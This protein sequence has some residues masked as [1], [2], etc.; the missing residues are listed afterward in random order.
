M[1]IQKKEM[2]IN[3]L[4]ATKYEDISDDDDETNREQENVAKRD[5]KVYKCLYCAQLHRGLANVKNHIRKDHAGSNPR[6]QNPNLIR[7]PPAISTPLI[8]PGFHPRLPHSDH[9]VLRPSTI[10]TRNTIP[11]PQFNQFLNRIPNASSDVI[12][13]PR[14]RPRGSTKKTIGNSSALPPGRPREMNPS[15]N[16]N[17]LSAR[18][19]PG[20]NIH[21]RFPN[22]NVIRSLHSATSAPHFNS[23][24]FNQLLNNRMSNPLV[25]GPPNIPDL[26]PF[27]DL[28]PSLDLGPPHTCHICKTFFVN[29]EQYRSHL[30]D[31]YL[32]HQKWDNPYA[33]GAANAENLRE[34]SFRGNVVM[35]A[36]PSDPSTLFRTSP[37]TLKERENV[38]QRTNVVN[39]NSKKYE[40]VPKRGLQESYKCY[41][42]GQSFTG[43]ANMNIHIRF[44]HNEQHY[45]RGYFPRN[46]SVR[47]PPPS[48]NEETGSANVKESNMDGQNIQKMS[49]N[50]PDTK[51]YEDISEDETSIC[52]EQEKVAKPNQS[53][54]YLNHMREDH[55]RQTY[56]GK[57]HPSGFLSLIPQKI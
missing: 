30:F 31:C 51:K 2:S 38:P 29:L 1:K 47:A 17:Q 27:T 46:F 12:R 26:N 18:I 7:P 32:Q 19:G 5:Q 40:Y 36:P 23:H 34:F 48:T 35:L 6:F 15:Q 24:D 37:K 13:R 3:R 45:D 8:G 22:P 20:F 49:N 56:E 41:L 33:V 25:M 28:N 4:D 43:L 52:I 54:W 21:P 53:Y 16:L 55:H 42:C 14:G 57:E 50:R 44:V 39:E 11:P 10:S 9:N